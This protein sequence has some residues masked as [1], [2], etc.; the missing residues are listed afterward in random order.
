MKKILAM[1][2]AGVLAMA[3]VGCGGSESNEGG[4]LDA[5]AQEQVQ[6]D[7][8][9]SSFSDTGAGTFYISTPAGT[10]EGGN[11]PQLIVEKDTALTQIGCGTEGMEYASCMVYIDGMESEEL[12]TSDM[13]QGSLTLSGDALAPGVHTVEVVKMDGDSPAIYKIAQYEV[14]E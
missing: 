1:A 13:M 12:V 11:I 8:D 3:L 9:G 5:P 10:S 2:A 4:S 6:K 14:A 7:F